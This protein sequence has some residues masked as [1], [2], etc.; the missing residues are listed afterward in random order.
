MKHY[1]IVVS[2]IK[3]AACVETG[4]AWAVVSIK[5]F[6]RKGQ[7]VTISHHGDK[8]VWIDEYPTYTAFRVKTAQGNYCNAL[9]AI[10][11]CTEL[12][13]GIIIHVNLDADSKL[14][15]KELLSILPL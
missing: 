11:C 2:G 4:W 12:I 10:K 13:E 6:H 8:N 9:H 15:S 7:S 14:V 1:P 5:V 3:A